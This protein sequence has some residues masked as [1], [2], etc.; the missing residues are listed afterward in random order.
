MEQAIKYIEKVRERP[1]HDSRAISYFELTIA[2]IRLAARDYAAALKDFRDLEARSE[3]EEEVR[4][5]AS[6]GV[7]QATFGLDSNV[8]ADYTRPLYDRPFF[9]APF[10]VVGD[11]K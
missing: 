4:S 9:W 10:I 11:W 1:Q 2:E 8:T 3:A 7:A 6:L 5:K